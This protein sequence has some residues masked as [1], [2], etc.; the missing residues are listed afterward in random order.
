MG[1][2]SSDLIIIGG[3]VLLTA[4][5]LL[6]REIYKRIAYPNDLTL[7][8]LADQLHFSYTGGR[9]LSGTYK[10]AGIRIRRCS[11]V[12]DGGLFE[13]EVDV[14]SPVK[15]SLCP[16]RLYPEEARIHNLSREV[17]SGDPLFDDRF[18][19]VC[20]NPEKAK[21]FL[22]QP[23]TRNGIRKLF[24]KHVL[25][26]QLSR[27]HTVLLKQGIHRDSIRAFLDLVYDVREQIPQESMQDE[28]PGFVSTS[29]CS[30][31]YLYACCLLALGACCSMYSKTTFL[32]VQESSI[33]MMASV[34][35]G[36]IAFYLCCALV[37]LLAFSEKAYHCY[38]SV[39]LAVVGAY[40]VALYGPLAV[41]QEFDTGAPDKEDVQVV[42]KYL[43]SLA[44]PE[45][46]THWMLHVESY[47]EAGQSRIVRL[48]K[49]LY[50]H[51]SEGAVLE[52]SL[53]PGALG[54]PWIAGV[55]PAPI[56][57]ARMQNGV[58]PE[59]DAADFSS[60]SLD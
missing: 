42:G 41:N 2:S 37:T 3:W 58:L 33:V 55:K 46:D 29:L 36:V 12:D 6:L 19:P 21:E 49:T 23:A 57:R 9:V 43:S 22:A 35:V 4:V 13:F 60:S 5:I 48:D 10:G 31:M 59:G 56:L 45:D 17:A 30:V 47:P 7:Q 15:L 50:P 32:L 1:S 18:A 38:R 27:Q 53:R 24:S 8:A 25:C 51:I 11:G 16:T 54:K 52:L 39:P 44:S 20:S 40:L 34:F 14:R 28:V 26:W